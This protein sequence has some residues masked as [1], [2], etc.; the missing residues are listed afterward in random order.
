[1]L[2]AAIAAADALRAAEP[3]PTR[4][5]FGHS[6][7]GRPLVAV[8]AGDP[9]SARKA[10]VVGNIHGDEPAGTAVT[11]QLLRH[12]RDIAGVDLWVVKT[13]NPDGL[14]RRTRRN[15][16]GVD[17]NRNFSYR[18][19]GGVSASSGYYP[20]RRPFSEPESR[21]IRELVGQVQPQ[22]SIWFHQ[23]WNQVLA[24]CHGDAALQR[25]FALLSGIPLQRCRAQHETSR[26]RR[27]GRSPYRGSFRPCKRAAG[28]TRGPGGRSA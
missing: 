12:F 6:V 24:P 19:Q 20:G 2:A 9:E 14:A 8:R 11:R 28:G 17:L 25:R 1:M 23:P 22:L 15:S 7:R 10:L 16:H 21:A 18:W 26:P 27:Q 5:V 13:V 4:V 3:T